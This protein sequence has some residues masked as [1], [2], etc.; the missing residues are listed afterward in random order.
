MYVAVGQLKLHPCLQSLHAC[1]ELHFVNS[2]HQMQYETCHISVIEW[3]S[4]YSFLDHLIITVD[5]N[6]M[7]K[8]KT[9]LFMADLVNMW[10]LKESVER[11]DGEPLIFFIN[12]IKILKLFKNIL[13]LCIVTQVFSKKSVKL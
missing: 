13:L 2:S 3:T 11:E 9:V 4:V 7:C 1:H 12:K 5:V 6:L 10:K 8:I